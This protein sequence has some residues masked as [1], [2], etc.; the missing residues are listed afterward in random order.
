MVYLGQGID[1][2]PVASLCMPE[3]EDAE[4]ERPDA[5]A[6]DAGL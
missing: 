3:R 1:D 2:V 6:L 5:G 4:H